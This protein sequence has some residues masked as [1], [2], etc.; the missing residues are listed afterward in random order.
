[1]NTYQQLFERY[2]LR[3]G[4]ELKNRIVM[5]PMT[6]RQSFENGMITLDEI[7]YYK[8]RANGVSLLITACAYVT[9]DGRAFKGG[10]SIA[11]DRTIDGHRKLAAAIKAQGAKAVLQIF[12]GGRNVPPDAIGCEQPV[13]ASGIAA[14]REGSIVPRE[15]TKDEVEQLV[16]AFGEA[17]RRAIE[18]GYDGVE[19][20][21]ANTYLIQQ[22]FSPQS[23]LRDDHWGGSLVRRMQFPLAVARTVCETVEKYA[24]RPFIIGYRISP[25]EHHTPGITVADTIQ[26]MKR[27]TEL[28]L[29]YLHVSLPNAWHRSARDEDERPIITRLH[30]AVGDKI[31]LIAVGEIWQPEEA[32]Q[33]L[34]SGIPFVALGRALIVEPGWVEKVAQN[35]SAEIRLTMHE[36]DRE[37]LAISFAMWEYLARVPG[38]LPIEKE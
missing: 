13:S 10:P 23:N 15:L 2:T 29:D 14:V 35:R 25:E 16:N 5:A 34:T 37:P 11:N 38:W 24:E 33:V 6:A 17:T 30:E 22:F 20:H 1:M 36:R 21:G 28:P 18:A 7:A 26:L 12:H 32:L 27:L 4:V 9:E 31:P 3:S 8:R 19:I